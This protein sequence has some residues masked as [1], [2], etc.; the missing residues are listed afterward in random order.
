MPTR[1]YLDR[2][3]HL[4]SLGRLKDAKAANPWL[5]FRPPNTTL[6]H[7]A[8]PLGGRQALIELA[9][10]SKDAHV[11]KVIRVHDLPKQTQERADE[12]GGAVLGLW[13]G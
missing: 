4:A 10:L 1:K 13:G 5:L 9:R 6:E 11:R 2:L 8:K 7:L 3:D 12:P